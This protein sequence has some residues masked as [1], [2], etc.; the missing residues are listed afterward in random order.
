MLTDLG[1]LSTEPFL[2]LSVTVPLHAQLA[3]SKFTSRKTVLWKARQRRHTKVRYSGAERGNFLSYPPA[4]D[5]VASSPTAFNSRHLRSHDALTPAPDSV[6]QSSG[7]TGTQPFSFRIATPS[8]QRPL[9]I[10]ER[11]LWTQ[12][13]EEPLLQ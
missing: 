2:F 12:Q 5:R 10:S 6:P 7:F 11:L 1:S 4:Q 9:A 3:T 8:Y 13:Q